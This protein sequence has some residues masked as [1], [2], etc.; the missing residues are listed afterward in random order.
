MKIRILENYADGN[1]YL[2]TERM[3]LNSLRCSVWYSLLVFDCLFFPERPEEEYDHRS[4]FERLEEQKHKRELEYEEA[5]KLSKL[6]VNTK[7]RI[8]KMA[9]YYFEFSCFQ[10]NFII[11]SSRV[12][13]RMKTNFPLPISL[14]GSSPQHPFSYIHQLLLIFC[15]DLL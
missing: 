9:L 2:D 6:P 3:K 5:H 1:F 7:F 13:E 15:P 12:R 10:R 11:C 14:T 4:L 8:S